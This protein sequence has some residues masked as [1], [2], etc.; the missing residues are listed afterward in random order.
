MRSRP[1]VIVAVAS[2]TACSIWAALDNPY[3]I[4]P[5]AHP[6]GSDAAPSE[7]ADA[8]DADAPPGP[9]RVVDAGFAP[10]AI[11]VYGDTVYAV[12]ERVQ[13]HAAYDAGTNF[14]T[15]WAG[16]G[17]DTFLLQANAI[18]ASQAGVFWTVAAGVRYCA[19]DGGG[20]G[21]LASATTPQAIAASDSVVAWIDSIGVRACTMPLA[22]CNPVVLAASRGARH[23]AAGPG[24][25]V[26]WSDG[27]TT[28]HF[29]NSAGNSAIDVAPH[30]VSVVATDSTSGNLYWEGQDAVGF[31]HFDGTGDTI[32]ANLTSGSRPTELFAARGVVY[33]SL[34]PT[35]GVVSY[36]RF[37][38]AAGC[39]PAILP[40]G[41]MG[42]ATTN[43]GIVANSR[44]VLA[45]VSSDIN[46]FTPELFVWRLPP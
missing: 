39:S 37:D 46:R 41:G 33:W 28:I 35:N 12:D 8:G 34:H 19:V 25:A 22:V 10:Y 13:I 3:K 29:A 14:T 30:D 17:G 1:L 43:H 24:G 15:F 16:D 5:M 45:I 21:F 40:T 36:C 26:A 18:A 6:D 38:S 27:G 42:A 2:A 11:A 32:S 31:V 9:N 23:L 20:C 7:L 4:E 44:R